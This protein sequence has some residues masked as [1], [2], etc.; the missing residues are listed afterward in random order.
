[1]VD[2]DEAVRKELGDDVL[3]ANRSDKEAGDL[4]GWRA[5][6]RGRGEDAELWDVPH[7]TV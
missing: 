7:G 5:G 3:K 1:M 6:A 4:H 2:G